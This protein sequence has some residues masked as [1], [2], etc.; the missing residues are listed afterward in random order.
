MLTEKLAKLGLITFSLRLQG[1]RYFGHQNLWVGHSH[2][3]YVGFDNYQ[4]DMVD[5]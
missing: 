2:D 4:S 5:G 1:Y 3:H